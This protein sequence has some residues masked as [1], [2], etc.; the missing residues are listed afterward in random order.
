MQAK[1]LCSNIKLNRYVGLIWLDHD[2]EKKCKSA[3]ERRKMD[4]FCA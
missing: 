2:S 4:W 1:W 3:M